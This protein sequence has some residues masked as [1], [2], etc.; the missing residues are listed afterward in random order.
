[1]IACD[2][3][4]SLEQMGVERFMAPMEAKRGLL[5]TPYITWNVYFYG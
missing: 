2:V 4:L 1:M 5:I 3:F